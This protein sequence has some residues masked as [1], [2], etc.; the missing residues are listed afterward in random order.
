MRIEL[1]HV[2]DCP[3]LAVARERVRL[4]LDRAGVAASVTETEATTIDDAAAAGMHGSPTILID[5]TD[6]FAAPGDDATISCR[7]YRTTDGIDGAPS[8]EELVAVLEGRV[9][10][11]HG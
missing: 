2:A 1:L 7:L 9:R 4:A 8:V 3:N 5:G 11:G 6:P 10:A